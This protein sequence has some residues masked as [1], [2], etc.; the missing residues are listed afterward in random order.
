[1][2]NKLESC[3][4]PF[5]RAR[6]Q[7]Q[8]LLR[9]VLLRSSRVMMSFI[10]SDYATVPTMVTDQL[11][12][13]PGWP[14]INPLDISMKANHGRGGGKTYKVSAPSEAHACPTE[15]A[16]HIFQRGANTTLMSR[17]ADAATTFA[18]SGLAPA[19]L[20]QGSNFYIQTWEGN[21]TRVQLQTLEDFKSL[22]TV[23]AKIH[24]LPTQWFDKHRDQLVSEFPA[25]GRVPRGSHAWALIHPGLLGTF[26]HLP[27]E[28][29]QVFLDTPLVAPLNSIASRVV[30]CHIDLH[31]GNL[32]KT[33]NGLV[34]IDFESACVTFAALDLALA[35]AMA[36]FAHAEGNLKVEFKRTVIRSYLQEMG[37]PSDDEHVEDLIFEAELAR[38]C[39]LHSRL[40]PAALPSGSPRLAINVIEAMH[41]FVSRARSSTTLREHMIEVG[42]RECAAEDASLALAWKACEDWASKICA[43]GFGVPS[44]ST[45]VGQSVDNEADT[46]SQESD[47]VWSLPLGIDDV[48]LPLG[49]D[50]SGL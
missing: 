8:V 31:P 20:A 21:G 43:R 42:F 34:C 6:E 48:A 40:Q 36:G 45:D 37:E 35:M 49:F 50:T 26:S 47:N 1:M 16:V 29:L 5:E 17:V 30:T 22:G 12:H 15:V 41:S 24:A 10:R 44:G 7:A 3:F 14:N 19:W 46:I 11:S 23:L 4:A 39:Y 13:C 2:S 38:A 9:S 28:A 32:L 33:D 25:L 27:E 18:A